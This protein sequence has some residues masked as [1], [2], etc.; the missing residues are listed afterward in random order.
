MIRDTGQLGLYWWGTTRTCSVVDVED[1]EVVARLLE[2]EDW[3]PYNGINVFGGAVI[4]KVRGDV[5]KDRE[6]CFAFFF[7]LLFLLQ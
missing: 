5:V 3:K 4:E 6:M 1:K 7:L 2:R